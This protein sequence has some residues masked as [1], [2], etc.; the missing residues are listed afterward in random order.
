MTKHLSYEQLLRHLDGELSRLAA[1]QAAAHLKTCW[2]CQVELDHLK[3]QIADIVDAQSAVFGPSLPP[4]PRPWPSLEPRLE[5]Q[6]ARTGRTPLW[7][8]AALF[9]GISFRAQLA[10]GIAALALLAIGLSNWFSAQPV[11]AKEILARVAAADGGRLAITERKVARQRVRVAKT[12][13]ASPAKL[14]RLD[15]WRSP[16]STYWDNAGDPIGAELQARYRSNGLE[17]NLPLSPEAMETWV[18]ITGEK[19][20]ASQEQGFIKVEVAATSEGRAHGLEG[21]S[22]HVRAGNWHLDEMT[23]AFGDATYRISEE[24]SSVIPRADVPRDVMAHLEPSGPVSIPVAE[25]PAVSR[26]EGARVDLDN[27]ELN[28]RSELHRIGADLLGAIEIAPQPPERLRVQVRQVP[29]ATKETLVALLGNR[30]G[31]QLEFPNLD[32]GTTAGARVTRVIPQ[33]GGSR[34]S[35]DPRVSEFF[36]SAEAQEKYTQSVLETSNSVLAHLHAL[37]ELAERWNEDQERALSPG[38]RSSLH[39]MVR[40]HAGAVRAASSGMR[41]QLAP[42]L[43]HFGIPMKERAPANQPGISWQAASRSALDAVRRV[44]QTL[45]ALL[46]ISDSPL[47]ADQALPRLR[48]GLGELQEAVIQP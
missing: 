47:P 17:A 21:V 27:L 14:A 16:K 42:L 9:S 46:T 23:L 7:R 39:A 28:V 29:P 41:T 5:Q 33:A 37:R 1:W 31:V 4:P 34:A 43:E 19:P 24:E 25:S 12:S 40:D 48:Q 38:A 11:L 20:S 36:G 15:A 18:R 10:Y 35:A 6:A 30:P 13:G 32:G 8:K 44:D 22:L 2:A 26:P 3:E 45:R